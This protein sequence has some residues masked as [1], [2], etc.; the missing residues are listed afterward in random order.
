MLTLVLCLQSG[1]AMAV[2]SEDAIQGYYYYWIT[3]NVEQG[4]SPVDPNGLTILIY[5]EENGHVWT[6]SLARTTIAADK[7]M[8]NSFDSFAPY[9]VGKKYLV[10]T[11]QQSGWGAGPEQVTISGSGVEVL[12][13]TMVEG[14]GVVPEEPPSDV[15]TGTIPLTIARDPNNPANILI[16]WNTS[17]PAYR[18]A[19]IYMLAGDGSGTFTNNTANWIMVNDP[20]VSAL[21]DDPNGLADG[22]LVFLGQFGATSTAPEA[23]F[24]AVQTRYGAYNVDPATGLQYLE[25][26]WAVGKFDVLL[27]RF[28]N[29]VSVP[30][31]TSNASLNTAYG[32]DIFTDGDEA[33]KIN[34]SVTPSLTEMTSFTGATNWQG[35]T[36]NAGEGCMIFMKTL[37][38]GETRTMTVLGEVARSYSSRMAWLFNLMGNPYPATFSNFSLGSIPPA[39]SGQDGDEIWSF[40]PAT[41]TPSVSSYRNNAWDPTVPMQSSNGYLFFRKNNDPFDWAPVPNY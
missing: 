26:A 6:D 28:W 21:F 38:Q 7:Y 31:L 2:T 9:E 36:I 35:L 30:F 8:L 10:A 37:P 34:T 18:D 15:P 19:E 20:A 40:D 12:N 41:Q 14:G 17:V 29:F 3:G 32:T 5:D 16:S 4:A 25:Q 23:Y 24:K 1:M 22:M 13:L 11:I 27:R 39:G 33:W